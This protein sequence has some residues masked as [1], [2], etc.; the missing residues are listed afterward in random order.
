M[1]GVEWFQSSMKRNFEISVL[2]ALAT[3]LF[4]G[5]SY[6]KTNVDDNLFIVKYRDHFE[7]Q[8]IYNVD[9]A[10]VTTVQKPERVIE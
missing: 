1:A 4:R 6:S 9:K 7:L 8:D 3:I 10:G 5:T 2:A